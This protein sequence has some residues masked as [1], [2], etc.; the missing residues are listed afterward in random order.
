MT[1]THISFADAIK[2]GTFGPFAI[3]AS[4]HTVGETF[5]EPTDAT[6]TNRCR[7]SCIWQYGT[8]E[9]HFDDDLLSLIHCDADDLFDGGPTLVIDP[10]KLKRKMPLGE[11]RTILDAKTLCYTGCDDRYAPDCT[12]KLASGC[13]LGF[14]LDSDAGLGPTGL[15]SWSIMNDG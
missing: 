1:A 4:R 15:R 14:V 2:R 12:L 10:W 9:F 3:G 6:I 5:G 7:T 13:S 8:I 11:L